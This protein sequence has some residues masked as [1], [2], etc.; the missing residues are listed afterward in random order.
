MTLVKL[1]T[2]GK[3]TI[4]MDVL[5]L[6]NIETTLNGIKGTCIECKDKIQ[7]SYDELKNVNG[8]S[9]YR[10]VASTYPLARQ[11]NELHS[12]PEKC[13]DYLDYRLNAVVLNAQA[14][15]LGANFTTEASTSIT[16]PC[17]HSARLRFG[18]PMSLMKEPDRV[19][20]LLK[21][22]ISSERSRRYIKWIY[23][24]EAPMP[25][26]Y[27]KK[28]AHELVSYISGLENERLAIKQ[29]AGELQEELAAMKLAAGRFQQEVTSAVKLWALE[30]DRLLTELQKAELDRIDTALQRVGNRVER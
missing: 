13:A 11:L 25:Q 26:A 27:G 30:D 8:G 22:D 24:G 7:L 5:G 19:E 17:G 10:N 3:D 2:A 28:R 18:E 14:D 9:H 12:H 16:L 15:A 23:A 21:L 29:K 1:A 4:P 6:S 20:I